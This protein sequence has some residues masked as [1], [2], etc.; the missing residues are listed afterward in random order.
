M[1]CQLVPNHQ[2]G[3]YRMSSVIVYRERLWPGLG[4]PSFLLFM[5]ASLAIAYE[6]AYQGKVGLITML[7]SVVVTVLATWTISP[8]I[9]VT[10]TELRV[11]KARIHRRHIGK[12]AI[13]EARQTKHALGAGAHG[14]A[15]T[16][17]RAAIKSSVIVEISDNEDP[18]PY[19][20]F[21][22]RK[23]EAVQS[24]LQS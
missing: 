17:T 8:V 24:A 1:G 18:H 5:G 20:Q 13:L 12:V 7:I 16:V 3:V 22:T 10:D 14:S 6:R 19:W 21:S 15:L 4:F 11:G 9:E 2:I 23:P